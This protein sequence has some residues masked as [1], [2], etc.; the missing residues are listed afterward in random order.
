MA[1]RPAWPLSL[2]DVTTHLAKS[3]ADMQAG[4]TMSYAIV[5]GGA[6]CGV[7]IS[8]PCAAP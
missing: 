5:A 7:S 8:G 2:V 4:I 1:Q 3:E 6:P